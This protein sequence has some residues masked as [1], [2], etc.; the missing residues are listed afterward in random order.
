MQNKNKELCPCG[1]LGTRLIDNKWYCS[2]HSYQVKR[3]GV[4]LERTRFDKNEIIK[5]EDYGEIILYSNDQKEVGRTFIDTEDIEKCKN[6]K[7]YLKISKNNKPYA[8]HRVGRIHLSHFVLGINKKQLD[9]Q[10][11]EV[12]HIDGDS[13]N[14]RKSNLRIVTHKKN[15]QNQTKNPSNNSSGRIGV[16]WN[17]LNENWMAQIKINQK[18]IHLGCFENFDDAVTARE[19]AEI[20][21]FGHKSL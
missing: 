9:K 19:D 21:F 4:I 2:K 7:W 12:D 11:M 1:K 8:Q 3:H 18:H 5:H 20:K 16:V 13:L 15:M 10:K 17:K 14:N 6:L